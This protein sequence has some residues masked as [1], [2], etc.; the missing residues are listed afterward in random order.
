MPNNGFKFDQ[1]KARDWEL[2]ADVGNILAP[3]GLTHVLL[4]GSGNLLVEERHEKETGHKYE[5]RIDEGTSVGLLKNASQFDWERRFPPRPGLP[6][7][8]I[9]E[10]TLRSREE[11]EGVATVKV[12]LRDAE[13]DRIMAPVLE[14]LRRNVDR[15]TDGKLFL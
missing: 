11:G 7:E 12:W 10:W 1:A 5:G 3:E 9:V 14:E 4:S 15:L 8:A 6:D 13:K 2:I